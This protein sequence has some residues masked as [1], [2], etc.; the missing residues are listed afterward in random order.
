MCDTDCGPVAIS[1]RL[2]QLKTV[3]HGWAN[4]HFRQ[5]HRLL[6]NPASVWEMFGGVL[7]HGLS[8]PETRGLAFMELPSAVNVTSGD[9]WHHR[10]LGVDIRDFA[11]DPAQ[12]L[13][14]LIAKPVDVMLC[15][16]YISYMAPVSYAPLEVLLNRPRNF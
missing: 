12:D 5:R 11:M 16:Y 13:L 15:V 14:V 2:S 4:L 10:D 6:S 8:G 3:Q 1:E 9:I 7:A